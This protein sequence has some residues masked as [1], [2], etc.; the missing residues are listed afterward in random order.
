[1]LCRLREDQWEK[2]LKVLVQVVGITDFISNKD[3]QYDYQKN[4][5]EQIIMKRS[6]AMM[7]SM[8]MCVSML[9]GCGSGENS[10][11]KKRRHWQYINRQCVRG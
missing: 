6:L 3:I 10:D 5:K 8:G 4:K 7:L 1:M 11:N 9:A 2:V